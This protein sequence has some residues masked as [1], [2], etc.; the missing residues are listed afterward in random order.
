MTMNRIPKQ[1]AKRVNDN[2]DH[3]RGRLTETAHVG[4][5][6][7]FSQIVDSRVDPT[8]TLRDE[9]APA[10]RS[11]RHGEGV[12]RELGLVAWE[13]LEDQRREVSIFSE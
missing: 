4:Q 3:E 12:G 9:D 8:T 2:L 11:N 10:I 6:H 7:E 1:P 13:V 5:E